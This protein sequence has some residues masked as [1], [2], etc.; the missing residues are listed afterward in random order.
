MAISLRKIKQCMALSAMVFATAPLSGCLVPQSTSKSALEVAVNEPV[1]NRKTERTKLVDANPLSGRLHRSA[2]AYIGKLSPA[3]FNQ[4]KYLPLIA[5][6]YVPESFSLVKY[7]IPA[8]GYVLIYGNS[9]GQC[10]AVEYDA[11]KRLTADNDDIASGSASDAIA[12]SAAAEA[13]LDQAELDNGATALPE[14][15][16]AAAIATNPPTDQP[17]IREE[18]APA[19]AEPTS[20][21]LDFEVFDSPLFGLGK[22]L[23]YGEAAEKIAV[24]ERSLSEQSLNPDDTALD[25]LATS[26]AEAPEAPISTDSAPSTKAASNSATASASSRQ[27]AYVSEWLSSDEGAYRYVSGALVTQNYS[28]QNQCGNVSLEESVKIVTSFAVL[29]ADSTGA[30]ESN[31]APSDDP[32]YSG[33]GSQN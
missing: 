11:S 4:L 26:D 25:F 27:D 30:L 10:F 23:F 3:I 2:D 18:S 6:A 13:S 12:N 21:A 20:A 8:S 7:D 16:A 33:E 24:S 14:L 31:L 22:K 29:S 17:F 15:S 32:E 19:A 9:A 1:G 5:P 28:A